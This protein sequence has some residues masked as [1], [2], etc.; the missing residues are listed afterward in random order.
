MSP[1]ET[2]STTPEKKA[3]VVASPQPSIDKADSEETLSATEAAP[4]EPTI[5]E[6]KA[7]PDVKAA[8][9]EKKPAQSASKVATKPAVAAKPAVAKPAP[10]IATPVVPSADKFA[11]VIPASESDVDVIAEG[12][13]LRDVEEGVFEE[14]VDDEVDVLRAQQGLAQLFL[15]NTKSVQKTH[16]FVFVMIECLCNDFYVEDC[17]YSRDTCE[18]ERGGIRACQT[19]WWSLRYVQQVLLS[20]CCTDS[21]STQ[22]S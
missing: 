9:A 11:K 5:D 22:G 10:V 15:S 8:V 17:C 21:S 6:P 1:K 4:V 18:E 7:E 20:S 2:A 13:A 16:I 3:P 14:P 19:I 12:V